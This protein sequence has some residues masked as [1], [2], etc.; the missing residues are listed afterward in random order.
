MRTIEKRELQPLADWTRQETNMIRL[1]LTALIVAN[2]AT[3]K[4]DDSKTGSKSCD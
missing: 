4:A 3:L 1:L 2:A